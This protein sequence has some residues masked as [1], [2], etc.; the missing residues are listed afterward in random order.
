MFKEVQLFFFQQSQSHRERESYQEGPRGKSLLARRCTRKTDIY[1]TNMGPWVYVSQDSARNHRVWRVYV[2][3]PNDAHPM[4]LSDTQTRASASEREKAI[5]GP[6][7]LLY[8]A[9]GGKNAFFFASRVQ[10]YNMLL[11][12]GI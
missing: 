7:N 6:Y 12:R 3:I 5:M 11:L 8:L 9:R 2:R 1:T 4:H 10:H